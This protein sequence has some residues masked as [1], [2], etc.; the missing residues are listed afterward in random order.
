MDI[1]GIAGIVAIGD[2]VI[3]ATAI[4]VDVVRFLVR[5]WQRLGARA[6]RAVAAPTPPSSGNPSIRNNL[7]PSNTRCVAA[8]SRLHYSYASTVHVPQLLACEDIL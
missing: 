1:V 5:R 7:E 3:A 8:E 4:A 6:P 2:V